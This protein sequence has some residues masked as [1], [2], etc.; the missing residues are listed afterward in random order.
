M[1]KILMPLPARDVDPT[2]TG[3]PWRILTERGHELVFATPTGE[4]GEAD[5]LMVTGKGLGLL[6][7]FLR[8]NADG[9]AA[10]AAMAGTAARRWPGRGR[11]K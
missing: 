3:V 5:P 4:P 7:P 6:A 11:W 10:Y 8:A 9:R 1:A 2:E